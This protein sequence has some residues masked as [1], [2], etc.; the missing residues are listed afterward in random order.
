MTRP[1]KY[2]N[3]EDLDELCKRFL[4]CQE[5]NPGAAVEYC[6][7]FLNVLTAKPPASGAVLSHRAKSR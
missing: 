7:R 5:D 4:A 1:R 2:N 3:P 6:K